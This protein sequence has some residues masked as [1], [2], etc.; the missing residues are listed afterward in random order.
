M[1]W[2]MVHM[3]NGILLRHLKEWNNAICSNI[4][5][6]GDYHIKWGKSDRERQISDD[7]TYVTSKKWYRWTYLQS[8]TVSQ[9]QRMNLWLPGG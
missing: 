9:A 2:G 6:T 1:V 4:D 5:G 7:I 3:Y 8:E